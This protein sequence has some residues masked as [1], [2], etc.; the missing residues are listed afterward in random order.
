MLSMIGEAS[1]DDVWRN[2]RTLEPETAT[3]LKLASVPGFV[4]GACTVPLNDEEEPE[5]TSARTE[6]P[7]PTGVLSPLNRKLTV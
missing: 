4:P 2:L 7:P 5:F 1:N 3:K 6:Y